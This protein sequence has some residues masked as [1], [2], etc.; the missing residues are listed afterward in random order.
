MRPY[1][2]ERAMTDFEYISK[3]AKEAKYCMNDL[4]TNKK[5]EVLHA[6]AKNLVAD[7][8][9]ILEA[10]EKDMEKAVAAGMN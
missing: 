8:K 4:D 2:K 1:R 6:V 10:N 7:S 9:I 3:I 5:N